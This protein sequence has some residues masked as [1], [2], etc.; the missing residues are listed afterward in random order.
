MRRHVFACVDCN[1]FCVSCERVFDAKLAR[2][3]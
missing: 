3:D 2:R 1:N